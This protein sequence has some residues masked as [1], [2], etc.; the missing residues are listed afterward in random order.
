[1]YLF[2]Y[3]EVLYW[4]LKSKVLVRQI[5]ILQIAQCDLLVKMI[6]I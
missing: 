4:V 5:L 3:Q 6:D 2:D 1:M